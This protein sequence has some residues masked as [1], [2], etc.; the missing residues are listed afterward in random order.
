MNHVSHVGLKEQ[1]A[2][3]CFAL[4]LSTFSGVPLNKIRGHITTIFSFCKMSLHVMPEVISQASQLRNGG[5]F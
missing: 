2:P 4:P 1:Q 3:Q 5:L